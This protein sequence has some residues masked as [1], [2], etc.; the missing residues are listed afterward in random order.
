[1]KLVE[2]G[3]FVARCQCRAC[4]KVELAVF[5]ADCDPDS[6]ECSRCHQMASEAK[7]YYPPDE[8]EAIAK[9]A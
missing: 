1:M 2:P 7:W 6:M 5:P 4:G 3:W 8:A 9:T